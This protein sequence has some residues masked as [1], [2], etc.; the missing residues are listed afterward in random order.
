[1][2]TQSKAIMMI[3]IMTIMI[4]NGTLGYIPNGTYSGN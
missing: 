4:P 3:N 2:L 1:M